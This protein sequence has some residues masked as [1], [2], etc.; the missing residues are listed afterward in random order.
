M[1]VQRLA[2]KDNTISMLEEQMLKESQD[3]DVYGEAYF[4]QL[5]IMQSKVRKMVPRI[6]ELAAAI[7]QIEPMYSV[8]CVVM[9]D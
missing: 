9:I 2:E 4:R 7:A 1:L 3:K 6:N 5:S 8:S